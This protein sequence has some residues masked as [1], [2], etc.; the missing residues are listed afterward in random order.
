MSDTAINQD[1]L[2]QLRRGSW[3]YPLKGEV[4]YA[5]RFVDTITNDEYQLKVTNGNLTMTEVDE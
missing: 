2:K 3:S 5:G 1:E 4:V